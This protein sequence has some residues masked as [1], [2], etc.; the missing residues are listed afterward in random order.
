MMQ[1]DAIQFKSKGHR[2]KEEQPSRVLFYKPTG[3]SESDSLLPPCLHINV[4]KKK[5]H[6]ESDFFRSKT[7]LGSASRKFRKKKTVRAGTLQSFC[8]LRGSG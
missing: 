5:S 2:V 4:Y 8:A 1:K 7:K 6:T 3:S